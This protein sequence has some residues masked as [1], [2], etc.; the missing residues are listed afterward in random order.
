MAPH[1]IL[2]PL[3]IDGLERAAYF[4]RDGMDWP[5]EGTIGTELDQWAIAFFNQRWE[6]EGA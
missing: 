5:T 4:Y 6:A 3:G 2:I 1:V